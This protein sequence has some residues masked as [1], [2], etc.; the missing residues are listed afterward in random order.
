M[1]SRKKENLISLASIWP[2]LE[3]KELELGGV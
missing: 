3:I 2:A 1:K